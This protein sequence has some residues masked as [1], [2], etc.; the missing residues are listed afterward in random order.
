MIEN[1]KLIEAM[2]LLFRLVEVSQWYSAC[3]GTLKSLTVLRRAFF[4][5]NQSDTSI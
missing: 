5:D 2:F 3:T 1:P 4:F